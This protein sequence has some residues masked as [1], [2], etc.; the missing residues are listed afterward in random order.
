MISRLDLPAN[1]ICALFNVIGNTERAAA[2][3]K[4]IGARIFGFQN[5]FESKRAIHERSTTQTKLLLPFEANSKPFRPKTKISAS[6]EIEAGAALRARA[7]SSSLLAIRY[8]SS[9]AAVR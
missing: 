4:Q 9:W 6:A 1:T 8:C 7:I 2:G 5:S 3:L